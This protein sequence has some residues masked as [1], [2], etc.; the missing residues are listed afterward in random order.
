MILS[1]FWLNDQSLETRPPSLYYIKGEDEADTSDDDDDDDDN[2]EKEE[3]DDEE[4]EKEDEEIKGRK[5]IF[6]GGEFK[7]TKY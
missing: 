1:F 7:K 2:E 5:D 6:L 4:E 3:D